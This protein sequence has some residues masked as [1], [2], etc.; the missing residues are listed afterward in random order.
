LL[1]AFSAAAASR[2]A[3]GVLYGALT[4]PYTILA[5][6]GLA[7][8][9]AVLVLDVLARRTSNAAAFRRAAAV[10]FAALAVLG[11]ARWRRLLPPAG[12]GP[13]R[14]AAGTVRLP[15][16]RAAAL[17]EVLAFLG[18]AARPGDG[19]AGFP[20]TGFVNFATGL[21]NPLRE[22]QILPG[23]LDAA[24]ERRVVARLEDD[25]TGPRFVLVVNQAAPAFG[26]TA[27]GRDYGVSIW[28]AVARRYRLAA[29]FG[30]GPPDAPFGDPR[31]FLRVYER[32]AA[33]P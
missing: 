19:V 20:E 15:A 27:F 6:P 11:A 29:S 25:R 32:A 14:T 21:P 31:F 8:S 16:A 10:V 12:A 18:R 33:P 7:A 3:L 5:V 1:F 2:V 24:A 26:A 23:H 9:A 13:V 22:E 30:P 4:T 17:S 28:R